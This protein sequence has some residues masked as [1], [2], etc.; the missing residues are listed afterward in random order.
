MKIDLLEVAGRDWPVQQKNKTQ[1]PA[2][3][4][5]APELSTASSNKTAPSSSAGTSNLVAS[6]HDVFTEKVRVLSDLT[7]NSE[8]MDRRLASGEVENVHEVMIAAAKA[9]FALNV[10]VQLRNLILRGFNQLTQLR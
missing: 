3:R 8:E 2:S 9:E 1:N 4:L 10:G 6:F 7:Q 5:D